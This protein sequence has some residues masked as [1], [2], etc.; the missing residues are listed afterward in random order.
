MPIWYYF[1]QNTET[2]EIEQTGPTFDYRGEIG[3]RIGK[4]III[5]YAEEYVDRAEPKEF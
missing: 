4:Y 2:G 1:M 3:D 5:D